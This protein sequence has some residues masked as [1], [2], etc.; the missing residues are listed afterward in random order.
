[1]L[2]V[3]GREL[4]ISA[5]RASSYW[6][7]SG[8]VALLLLVVTLLVWGSEPRLT[9]GREG[10]V[11]FI[12]S[13]IL[14]FVY[15]LIS[16]AMLT[17]DCLSS[18]RREGTLPLLFLTDL[19]AGHVV[20]GKML[21]SSIQGFYFF[22][23]VI[24]ALSIGFLFGGID[25][26]LV[27]VM[28][29]V[30]LNTL[31]VSLELGVFVSSRSLVERK[32]MM[33]TLLA[34]GTWVLGPLIL[35]QLILGRFLFDVF[36]SP[37]DFSLGFLSPLTQFLASANTAKTVPEKIFLGMALSQAL[38]LF[39]LR[40]A[41]HR[42]STSKAGEN[43]RRANKVRM[44]TSRSELQQLYRTRLLDLS[45]TFWIT[46]REPW[47]TH[48]ALLFSFTV[49]GVVAFAWKLESDA[50]GRVAMLAVAL[51]I[52]AAFF[53]MW[54]L[55]E[56]C[57]RS[58]ED[59]QT[60]ALELLLTTPLT[61]PRMAGG[62]HQALRQW[63]RLAL[64]FPCLCFGLY[65]F[66]SLQE[67]TTY[68]LWSALTVFCTAFALA[69]V[70][71]WALSWIGL[72]EAARAR[73]TLRAIARALFILFWAPVS[74]VVLLIIFQH[75]VFM[76]IPEGSWFSWLIFT[77][78][79]GLGFIF[80]AL[81]GLK[82][83]RLY[84]FQLRDVAAA[85]FQANTGSKRLPWKVWL[86]SLPT[87]LRGSPSSIGRWMKSHPL[88]AGLCCLFLM[89]VAAQL[90]RVRTLDRQ[91]ERRIS[92]IEASGWSANYS[93]AQAVSTRAMSNHWVDGTLKVKNVRSSYRSFPRGVNDRDAGLNPVAI[94]EPLAPLPDVHLSLVRPHLARNVDY[95]DRI[96]LAAQTDWID[97]GINEG[98]NSN[99]WWYWQNSMLRQED[100]SMMVW[101]G[102][103][104]LEDSHV[105]EAI[106]IV[107]QILKIGL[108]SIRTHRVPGLYA[109]RTLLVN[110]AGLTQRILASDAVEIGQI[111]HLRD[112]WQ[113]ME[114][115]AEIDPEMHSAFSELVANW[116]SSIFDQAFR[117]AQQQRKSAFTLRT[118]LTTEYLT[119]QLQINALANLDMSTNRSLW[120]GA[121]GAI[122]ISEYQDGGALNFALS[123]EFPGELASAVIM[124]R[125]VLGKAMIVQ[126]G[127][128]LRQEQ[129]RNPELGKAAWLQAVTNQLV[130]KEFG[131]CFDYV[132]QTNGFTIQLLNALERNRRNSVHRHEF[133]FE[134][135]R[136]DWV[137]PAP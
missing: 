57:Q 109:A 38:G 90:L 39:L 93:I 2:P 46:A 87:L 63:F 50:D 23:A 83:R 12:L 106:D 115:A 3:V 42:L 113:S 77:V 17:S 62:F 60:N 132:W 26:H 24:P 34:V 121:L 84:L 114:E 127:L 72:W 79:A 76:F 53:K 41:T 14:L 99:V 20:L 13:S 73:S 8:F 95:F 136:R 29:F 7:R 5:R 91:V 66:Y 103:V 128:A 40:R 89:L 28:F 130:F 102:M 117:S 35:E 64:L 4:L 86:K 122:N 82:A 51:W 129:L 22:L 133:H 48:V 119:G 9:A 49:L 135:R 85:R 31:I 70:D 92:E 55:F 75:V 98:P 15:S 32:A 71:L 33:G 123:S 61:V 88:W 6:T 94:P 69:A 19:K 131:S 37:Q 54:V 44:R 43:D 47:K 74:A 67:M 126:L 56:A 96:R 21:C 10:V 120:S 137:E 107:R 68:G 11:V 30:L 111:Q 16:G 116:N 78:Y 100:F 108:I 25:W 27:L 101:K 104:S 58:L 97:F 81:G 45:P 36:D 80:S 65:F 124:R 125:D 112:L 59:H 118:V 110:A 52:I 18:E 1:M 105:D 134:L